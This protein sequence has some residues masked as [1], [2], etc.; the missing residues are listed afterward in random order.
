MRFQFLTAKAGF[1][2]IND[3][4]NANPSSMKAAIETL[5]KLNAY[6]KKMI[7][8]GD[9]LELGKKAETYHREI[10]KMLN[11]DSIQYVF[12]YGELAKIVAEEARKNYHAG[13]VQSFDNKAEIA[14]EV[15]KV[16]T[17][18]DVVLLKGSRGM[19]LEEIVQKWI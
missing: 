8:I 2:I 10:G 5:Q 17:K 6:K 16:V 1:T 7:V 18:K 14:E 4:W 19:A 11:E 9:M 12:T 3:A 13:K 15:L